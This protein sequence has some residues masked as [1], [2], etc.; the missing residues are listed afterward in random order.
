[1]Y[2]RQSTIGLGMLLVTATIISSMLPILLP[3]GAGVWLYALGGMAIGFMVGTAGVRFVADRR[4]VWITVLL[5]MFTASSFSMLQS[6]DSPFWT[7]ALLI[8]F[9]YVGAK[10]TVRP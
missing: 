6:T 10:L 5:V 8:L 9:V 7:Y 3:N 2:Q 4:P 1:M